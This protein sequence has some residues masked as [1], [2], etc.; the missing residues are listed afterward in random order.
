MRLWQLKML[1][2]NNAPAIAASTFDNL[3]SQAID[4]NA[5]FSNPVHNRLRYFLQGC[6]DGLKIKEVEAKA[7]NKK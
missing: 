6:R 7:L 1:M 2:S 5:R 3:V 4:K